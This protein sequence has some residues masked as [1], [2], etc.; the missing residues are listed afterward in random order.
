MVEKIRQHSSVGL[1]VAVITTLLVGAVGVYILARGNAQ[2]IET[3]A[4]TAAAR[5]LRPASLGVAPYQY[6]AY[7]GS[8]VESY[9]DTGVKNYFA[10]FVTASDEACRPSWGGSAAGELA[11]ARANAIKTDIAALEAAG[12]TV[13]VSFGGANGTELA[14][15]C[16]SPSELKEAYAKVIEMYQMKRVDFDIESEALTSVEAGERRAAAIQALQSDQPDLQVWVTLPAHGDGLTSPGLKFVEQLI[17]HNVRLSGINIMAM[18]YNA[19]TVDMGSTAIKA[20]DGA[21]AQLSK[22]YP[23]NGSSALWRAMMVTVMAGYND[24]PD[25]VFTLDN[26][27]VLRNFA[28]QKNVGTLGLWSVSRDR[29]C[30][31]PS[32][33]Q[34]STSCSGVAQEPYEFLRRLDTR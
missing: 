17:Q 18:N 13:V 19:H 2:S 26:A 15:A 31:D 20:A 8:L 16:Q 32:V 34:P 33:S 25:E 6:V 9:R 10:A 24:T 21:F 29:A 22:L 28:D 3:A 4:P 1:V 11:S 30:V 7:S 27:T 5:L 12:G 23:K 14:V